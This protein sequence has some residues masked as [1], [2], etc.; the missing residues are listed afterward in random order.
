MA[1]RGCDF[2]GGIGNR[3]RGGIISQ[4][5]GE[6]A[7]KG[8]AGPAKIPRR[9]LSVLGTLQERLGQHLKGRGWPKSWRSVD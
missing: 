9:T 5:E 2:G 3:C 4:K 7:A 6:G 1:G 8:E